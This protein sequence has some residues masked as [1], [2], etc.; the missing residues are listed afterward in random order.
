MFLVFLL[1]CLQSCFFPIL[2]FSIY[3]FL[4]TFCMSLLS[5]CFCYYCLQW[6]IILYSCLYILWVPRLWHPYIPQYWQVFFF[7][8]ITYNL[9][10]SSFKCTLSSMFLFCG[11]YSW[12]PLFSSLGS[13]WNILQ[14]RLFWYLFLLFISFCQVLFLVVFLFFW[15]ILSWFFLHIQ[16]PQVFVVFFYTKCLYSLLIG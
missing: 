14:E 5:F 7:L 16:Y 9:S 6:L 8:L 1:K 15:D 11:P 13:V 2:V 4:Y 10:T 3:Y 12:A